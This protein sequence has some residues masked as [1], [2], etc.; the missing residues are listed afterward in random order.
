MRDPEPAVIIRVNFDSGFL[1][2]VGQEHI[3]GKE[4]IMSERTF[5]PPAAPLLTV[6]PYFSVWSMTDRL[7]D[8]DPC[9]WTG[10]P[11]SLNLMLRI[12]G[13]A[14]R[15]MGVLS[16]DLR[17]SRNLNTRQPMGME[18]RCLEVR[19]LTTHYEFCA[20]GVLL[21]LDFRTPFLPDNMQAMMRPVS[22]VEWKIASE[23][24][25][26]HRVELY[27]DVSAELC[28][29]D[30]N[31]AVDG[32]RDVIGGRPALSF[33]NRVQRPLWRSGD[34]V[35]I[36]WGRI[37]MVAP[38]KAKTSIGTTE[39]RRRFVAGEVLPEDA[40]P[41]SEPVSS[42][43]PVMACIQDFGLVNGAERGDF[44][45]IAY[46]DDLSIEYF[47]TQLPA[48]W[49]R[50]EPDFR[51][52]LTAAVRDYKT[53]AAGCDRMDKE[54][55]SEAEA[56]GGEKYAAICALSWRQAFAAHKAVYDKDGGLLFFSKENFSNGCIGTVDVSYPSMP[57][58][59]R[60]CP[61]LVRGMMRPIFRYA[62]SAD[63]PFEFAPHD[64]GC[65]PLANGQVYEGNRLEFQM[66][67]EECGNMLLMA[68]ALS[69][70]AKS[71][72]EFSTDEWRLLR[73]WASY[74]S[75]VGLDIE[76]QLCTDDFAGHLA[77]NANLAIKGIL[78][79]GAFAKLCEQHGRNDDYVF[80]MERAREL[81]AE[82]LSRA[83]S[84][85]HTVLAF[86]ETDSW[87]LKYNL[88]WDRLLGLNLFPEDLATK[89]IRY[90]LRRMLRYGVPL[91]NRR[92]YTKADW[93]VWIA[94]LAQD[95]GDFER[96]I[97][98]IYRFLDETPSRIPFGDW[99]GTTDALDQAFRAR[100][101]VGG[102]FLPFLSER[103]LP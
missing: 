41:G 53:L 74:L 4:Q 80:F 3:I 49:R 89:E 67:V 79:I 73:Q 32:N 95:R 25:K 55:T 21:S 50:Q 16:P 98:P 8:A 92:T 13:T 54:V 34:D 29:N 36:D 44:V 38:S 87:S 22:Y 15:V 91:D 96:L 61:D 69:H 46:D 6:D 64:V 52:M 45:A 24:G 86:G 59:L 48:A 85:D 63:W 100:S 19:P 57:L 39:L 77:G 66:P 28:I 68:A 99:Y 1:S 76:R 20:S 82:W 35:R 71:Q 42:G 90:Y 84:D 75:H 5:R 10:V 65:Y 30:W 102:V 18:Q 47:G 12:D 88:V 2:G 101:V 78:G 26:A 83:Q 23:D 14:W 97:A 9:H 43:L 94:S 37:W 40:L 81:A 70:Y 11:N 27:F 56:I 62:G 72:V 31:E 103:R 60:Y 17:N 33:G 51:D 93:Q 7:Y 58:F